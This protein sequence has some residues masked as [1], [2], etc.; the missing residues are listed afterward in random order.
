MVVVVAMVTV[1]VFVLEALPSQAVKELVPGI[2]WKMIWPLPST[3][4][5]GP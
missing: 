4:V 2:T 5:L 3:G 1:S